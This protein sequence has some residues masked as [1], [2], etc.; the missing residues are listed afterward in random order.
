MRSSSTA[1]RHAAPVA[2]SA[3][4][5]FVGAAECLAEPVTGQIGIASEHTGDGHEFGE[6]YED[7][8]VASISYSF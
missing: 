4:A 7:R 5:S 1:R 2:L 3:L 8:L 6:R